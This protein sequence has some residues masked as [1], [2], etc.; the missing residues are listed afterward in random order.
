[1]S[2]SVAGTK[3]KPAYDAIA[4]LV[5]GLV[6]IS[7]AAIFVRFSETEI[8]PY[9]TVSHR[10]WIA[11]IVLALWEGNKRFVQPH[12]SQEQAQ[13]SMTDWSL[14][15][16]AGTVMGVDLSLWALSLTQTSVANA[17]IL[18]NLAPLFTALG[19][20][21]LWKK[22]FTRRYWLGLGLA[23]VGAG[24]IGFG[25][26]HMDQWQG[27]AIALSSAMLFSIYLLT[28]EYLR[29]KLSATTILLGCSSIAAIISSAI[30]LCLEEHFFPMSW[31][32]WAAVIGL[33]VCSQTIG[34][35]LV[36]YSLEK[37]SSGIVAMTFLLE[38]A[39][40]A[41]IAW[42]I[43]SETLSLINALGFLMVLFGVY[44]SISAPIEPQTSH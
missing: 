14:L 39:L 25:D 23:L 43:F 44:Q 26:L 10:F 12:S 32:G 8:G 30:A 29:D 16:F 31:Q 11:T 24:T 27:D 36:T 35:G 20:W 42:I 34:H 1:M 40:A 21:L 22:G 37:L 3:D 41:L 2:Q 28:L 17:A 5:V 38:P 19:S 7:F 6:G 33:A 4:A 18:S 13:V 15:I 9:A